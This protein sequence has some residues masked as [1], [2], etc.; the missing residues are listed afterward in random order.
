[1]N[2]Q[3]SFAPVFA[4]VQASG[5]GWGVEIQQDLRLAFKE[6][7][8]D[9]LKCLKSDYII[10]VVHIALSKM[11]LLVR[12]HVREGG[13]GEREKKGE[14]QNDVQTGSREI[15]DKGRKK[16]QREQ[17]PHCLDCGL[18]QKT[19]ELLPPCW[20]PMIILQ[21][22]VP[23]QI[24]KLQLVTKQQWGLFFSPPLS[25]LQCDSVVFSPA[26]PEI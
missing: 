18:F 20:S 21:D 1:M 3:H 12:K 17:R 9:C 6:L 19:P 2:W 15:V 14:L 23:S 4:V 8:R 10:Q 11:A 5:W 22:C 26:G 24:N 7:C 16:K 13:K 25:V